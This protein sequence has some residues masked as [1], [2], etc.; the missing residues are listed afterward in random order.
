MDRRDHAAPDAIDGD[1]LV[2]GRRDGDAHDVRFDG[3]H[4]LVVLLEDVVVVETVDRANAPAFSGTMSAQATRSTP[5]SALYAPACLYPI[6]YPSLEGFSGSGPV[7]MT[8]AVYALPGPR[9]AV[10]LYGRL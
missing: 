1:V 10:T 5:S 2:D 9:L 6:A 7:P 3:R 8:A 4:H